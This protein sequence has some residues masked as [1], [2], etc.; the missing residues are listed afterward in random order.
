MK[1]TKI[2]DDTWYYLENNY[3][4]SEITL[5]LWLSLIEKHSNSTNCLKKCIKI[6][7]SKWEFYD[8]NLKD[9][10]KKYIKRTYGVIVK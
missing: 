4:G 7:W 10:Y 5:E 2:L 8:N 3:K 9:Y 1:Y 6:I